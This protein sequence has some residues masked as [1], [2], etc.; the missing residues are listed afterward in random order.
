MIAAFITALIAIVETML[1][2]GIGLFLLG[3]VYSA[4]TIVAIAF[5]IGY[6]ISS[7][8]YFLTIPIFGTNSA[9]TMVHIL[10]LVAA[11]LFLIFWSGKL[12]RI[13]LSKSYLASINK[14]YYVAIFGIPLLISTKLFT[15]EK[16]G[17]V[18]MNEV[19]I[20]FY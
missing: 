5:P 1:G 6:S 14:L 7:F 16:S 3:K 18:L 10:F 17:I 19:C 8:I 13:A 15:E 9:H 11:A 12:K 2:I 20:Y 4:Y